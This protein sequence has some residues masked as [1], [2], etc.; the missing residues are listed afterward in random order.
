MKFRESLKN[1][2]NYLQ[3]QMALVYNCNK[4]AVVVTFISGLQITN[5]FYKHL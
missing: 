4:D 2:V 3:S 5:S 1:Y